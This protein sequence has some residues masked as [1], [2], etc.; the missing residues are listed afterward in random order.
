MENHKAK[1]L[2]TELRISSQNLHIETSRYHKPKKTRLEQ[3]ICYFCN[4][5]SVEDERHLILDCM[6]YDEFRSTLFTQ[7]VAIC[8]FNQ[9]SE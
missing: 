8:D 9:L 5:Y 7:L 2:L 6:I 4:S 1:R 3:G